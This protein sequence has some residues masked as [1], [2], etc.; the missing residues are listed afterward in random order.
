MET[1]RNYIAQG[2][3]FPSGEDVLN[4]I[5]AGTATDED[6]TRFFIY[7]AS[8]SPHKVYAYKPMSNADAVADIAKIGIF[9]ER[10]LDELL[11]LTNK[12]P[13]LTAKYNLVLD[14]DYVLRDLDRKIILDLINEQ[15]QFN[16]LKERMRNTLI[17][18]HN[19]IYAPNPNDYFFLWRGGGLSRFNTWQSFSKSMQSA[20]GVMYQLKSTGIVPLEGGVNTYVINKNNMIDLDSLGLSHGNEQEII[21]LTE[22]A[23]KPGAKLPKDKVYDTGLD[24]PQ[25]LKKYIDNWAL[26]ASEPEFFPKNGF[27][28]EN[29]STQLNELGQSTQNFF[30]DLVSGMNPDLKPNKPYEQ[31]I[32]LN[33]SQLQNA[34]DIYNKYIAQGG[35]FNPHYFTSIPTVYETQI[36]KAQALVNMLDDNKIATPFSDKIKILDIGGTEGAWANTVAEIGG[37]KFSV[38]IIEPSP[39][40]NKLYNEIQ[41]PDNTFFR[42]EA[43]SYVIEDQGKF[44]DEPN[45]IKF[46]EFFAGGTKDS[47]TGIRNPDV[48]VQSSKYD[49]VHEAMAF[50]FV[51]KNRQAQIDFIA[52]YVLADDGILLIEEKFTNN[53]VIYQNNEKMK[54]DFKR[55]YYTEEQINSKA[56]NIVG[57]MG[58]KQVSVQEIENLLSNKFQYVNQYWDSGNFKGY[59]ASNNPIAETFVDEI[60]LLDTSLTN[61]IYSTAPTQEE[62]KYAVQK[63]MRNRG[64]D[65]ELAKD[66]AKRFVESNK[67][68]VQKTSDALGEVYKGAKAVGPAAG[69]LGLRGLAKVAPVLAPGDVL[70]EGA[71]GKVT[72]YIDDFAKRLG[73]ASLPVKQVLPTYIAA[74]IGAAGAELVSAAMYAYDE[75]QRKAPQQPSQFQESL[76]RFLLPKEYEEEAVQKLQIPQDLQSFLQNTC[77][78]K[79]PRR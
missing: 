24:T 17:D 79:I 30:N 78:R 63:D 53:D 1:N 13:E 62:L 50:Q 5:K 22:A 14:N 9:S 25:Q 20:S 61:H 21:V 2:Q 76:T 34:Q 68:F 74:D 59:I 18:A 64:I 35:D 69:A 40:A 7:L 72:P 45:S 55:L 51:D 16:N 52:D 26:T 73:F 29:I 10:P 12:D 48:Q 46:S 71:L 27:V 3:K 36:V 11:P 60:H 41:T 43:F 28:I 44:F 38:E 32:E 75:S 65:L 67:D 56:Q 23:N 57:P 31:I 19:K 33:N 54:D 15:G 6:I 8:K 4:A 39:S 77:R 42:N 70:V 49:V 47:N 37:E 58:N 66:F